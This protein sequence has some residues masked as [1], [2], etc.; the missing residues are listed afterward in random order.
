MSGASLRSQ[1][2]CSL[3]VLRLRQR[4]RQQGT[5]EGPRGGL[6]PLRGTQEDHRLQLVLTW[7]LDSH[8]LAQIPYSCHLHH[9]LLGDG[10]NER[11]R[12]KK[13]YATSLLH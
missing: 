3:P 10:W 7:D 6:G 12:K 8:L 2:S 9:M 13:E 11:E 4:Q 5:C 1:S